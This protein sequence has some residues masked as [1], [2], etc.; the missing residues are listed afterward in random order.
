MLNRVPWGAIRTP[1]HGLCFEAEV[2]PHVAR[3]LRLAL[4]FERNRIVGMAR[5]VFVN[6]TTQPVDARHDGGGLSEHRARA[7]AAAFG[8][9][10]LLRCS[11]Q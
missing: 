11:A 10:A 2:L 4:W 6:R 7:A 5:I 1:T 9:I 8:Q 3:L